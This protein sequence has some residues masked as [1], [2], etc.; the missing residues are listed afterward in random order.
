MFNRG[1]RG[2]IL[3]FSTAI[4]ITFI[5]ASLAGL[6]LASRGLQIPNI[7][8][9]DTADRRETLVNR[10]RDGAGASIAQCAGNE[11]SASA[12]PSIQKVSVRV[13]PPAYSGLSVEE[14]TGDAPVRALGGS[15]IE[16]VLDVNGNVIII[17]VH[18][19][20][21]GHSHVFQVVGMNCPS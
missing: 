21:E 18:G 16:V 12:L 5:A 10:E 15:Q 17:Y 2:N 9:W 13:L 4:G 19:N 7:S 20:S 14:T 11:S 1:L 8:K 6:A 3:A